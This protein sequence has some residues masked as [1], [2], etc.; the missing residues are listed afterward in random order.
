MDRLLNTHRG[1]RFT[2]VELL[3]VVLV[4]S[5]IAAIV[6]PQ[7]AQSSN[8]AKVAALQTNLA[9]LRSAIDLYYQ[10]HGHYP[11]DV[12]AN[13]ATCPAGGT[14]GIGT[15]TGLP[16]RATAFAEQL[17]M[18]T[19]LAGQACSTTDST[20]RYGPYIRTAELGE[21]GIPANPVTGNKAID[22]KTLG[23]LNLSSTDTDGG[24]KYDPTVGELVADH[25]DYD[26]L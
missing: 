17:T 8:D 26:D 21:E 2:L 1:E 11:G 24:W 19:N 6:V 9:R 23:D 22:V 5:I 15:A 3:I 25:Q 4:L 12:P 20:L 18:F 7:L 14:A 16:Q 13:G 10:A